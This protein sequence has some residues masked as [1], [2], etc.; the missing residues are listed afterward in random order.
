MVVFLI[1]TCRNLWRQTFG[2]EVVWD[3]GG[4]RPP[5]SGDN[6]N[7]VIFSFWLEKR[8]LSIL[9]Q[10]PQVSTII[11]RKKT[12]VLHQIKASWHKYLISVTYNLPGKN[13]ELRFL[14]SKKILFLAILW[15]CKWQS[16][17]FSLSTFPLVPAF[18]H[19][20]TSTHPHPSKLES[21]HTT[22]KEGPFHFATWHN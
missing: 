3:L 18:H 9:S 17:L 19:T 1:T 20:S 14:V 10:E 12:L 5:P 11:T 13:I 21:C 15:P 7:N 22:S 8:K 4:T 16:V 6:L 2:K